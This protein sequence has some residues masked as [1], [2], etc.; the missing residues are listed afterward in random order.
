MC[1]CICKSSY[2]YANVALSRAWKRM[3]HGWMDILV[4]YWN[5]DVV[6]LSIFVLLVNA[7]FNLLKPCISQ[8]WFTALFFPNLFESSKASFYKAKEESV[9]EPKPQYLIPQEQQENRHLDL[10][11]LTRPHTV[12]TQHEAWAISCTMYNLLIMLVGVRIF[13]QLPNWV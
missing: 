11:R 4:A 10:T 7:D 1:W 9:P 5:R 12:S 13:S 6:A 3:A 8:C 2:I